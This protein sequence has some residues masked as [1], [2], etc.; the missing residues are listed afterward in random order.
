MVKTQYLMRFL[1]YPI[2]VLDDTIRG[3]F[4]IFCHLRSGVN[5]IFLTLVSNWRNSAT[6]ETPGPAPRPGRG[7]E[8]ATSWPAGRSFWMKAP[9]HCEASGRSKLE[10]AHSDREL[11]R[12]GAKLLAPQN[13]SS[14]PDRWPL[15]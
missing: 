8:F 13:F 1:R 4:A 5:L 6:N 10:A 3:F 7:V 9:D 12:L 2:P 15:Q 11:S 14:L